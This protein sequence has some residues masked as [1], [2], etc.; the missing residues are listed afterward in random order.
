MKNILMTCIAVAALSAS[1][2]V[3]IPANPKS[4]FKDLE[5]TGFISVGNGPYVWYLDDYEI[6]GK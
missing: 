5:W 2:A 3:R 6:N 4:L 1:A